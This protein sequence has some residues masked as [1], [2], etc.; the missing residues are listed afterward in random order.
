MKITPIIEELYF[1]LKI[2]IQALVNCTMK[3]RY[4][5]E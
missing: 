2:M 1:S 3:Y 4:L 5:I